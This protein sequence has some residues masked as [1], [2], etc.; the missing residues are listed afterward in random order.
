MEKGRELLL[1]LL[2]HHY[3]HAW[4]SSENRLEEIEGLKAIKRKHL[5]SNKSIEKNY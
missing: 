5:K 4:N 1:L 2:S 3:W